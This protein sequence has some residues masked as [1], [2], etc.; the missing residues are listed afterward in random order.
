MSRKFKKLVR[1]VSGRAG[2][3]HA[4]AVNL[5]RRGNP[6]PLR[7]LDPVL[8]RSKA[9]PLFGDHTHEAG[10]VSAVLPDGSV[11]VTPACPRNTIGGVSFYRYEKL[12]RYRA[13]DV[14]PYRLKKGERF[15][16]FVETVFDTK[17]CF[18]DAYK[19]GDILKEMVVEKPRDSASFVVSEDGESILLVHKPARVFIPL[20][21]LSA[22]IEMGDDVVGQDAVK[23]IM[24]VRDRMLALID[25]LSFEHDLLTAG[26]SL[27]RHASVP[28]DGAE[29]YVNDLDD[30]L[31]RDR[32]MVLDSPP[33]F[34]LFRY[35][36]GR[37]K[38]GR[39]ISG[40][41]FSGLLLLDGD[42]SV[43]SPRP[44]LP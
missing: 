10:L 6:I 3:S 19:D 1:S 36:C 44:A 42:M 43:V 38:V 37:G 25:C 29:W 26:P 41:T 24:A 22:E 14:R 12:V 8:I 28:P 39:H 27:R 2:V 30:S 20:W 40:P 16:R 21:E 15:A 17:V 33:P 34:P 11:C 35:A 18:G 13:E 7:P 9:V 31:S 4:G 5:L 23:N 32:G